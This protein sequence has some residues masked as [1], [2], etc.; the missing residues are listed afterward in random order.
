MAETRLKCPSCEAVLKLAAP[1]A[2]G[3]AIK[4]PKCA[5]TIRAPAAAAKSNG[6]TGGNV[7]PA[8][9]PQPARKAKPEEKPDEEEDQDEEAPHP[10]KGA[11]RVADDE[12]RGPPAPTPRARRSRKARGNQGLVWGTVGGGLVVLILAGIL[13]AKGHFS[14]PKD[15]PKEEDT[16]GGKP[17]GGLPGSSRPSETGLPPLERAPAGFVQRARTH[18]EVFD[19]MLALQREMLGIYARV[20]DRD[21]AESFV[22]RLK[23]ISQELRAASAKLEELGDIPFDEAERFEAEKDRVGK[24]VKAELTRAEAIPGVKEVLDKRKQ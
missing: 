15:N 14:T 6:L 8:P 10:K 21:S 24:K 23:E 22:A 1:L 11:R 9:R 4:C 19:G 20:R 2:P 13:I 16:Q 17:G 7:L 12:D 3:K 5:A 18:R